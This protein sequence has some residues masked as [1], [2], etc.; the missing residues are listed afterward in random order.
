MLIS[1]RKSLILKSAGVVLAL[2]AL[3]LST[4]ATDKAI[5]QQQVIQKIEALVNDQVVSAFD[6][7]ERMGLVLMA[8]GQSIQNE[9]QLLQLREQV[10]E[11]LVNETL[12]VQEANE[13]DVPVPEGEIFDAYE[14]V[15]A[16]YNR[17]PDNFNELLKSFGSSSRAIIRQISAEYAWQ[18][19][20][21]GRYGSYVEVTDEEI[22]EV[23][24][25]LKDN[26]GQQEFRISE[27]FLSIDNPSL[28][29]RVASTAQQIRDQIQSY[30]QFSQIARQFSQS[31]TAAQ[32]GD[33]GWVREGQIP[34]EVM[35]V[36]KMIDVLTVSAPIKTT[37]G[38]YIIALTDRRMI[39]GVD[40]LDEL[41][42]LK[43][44]GWF[45]TENTTEEIA[46]AW[47]E[48]AEQKVT[49]FDSC[50]NLA[51]FA[52]ELGDGVLARDVGEVPL[53]QLNPELRTI[54]KAID[55]N[56]A[57]PPINTPD[58]FIIFVVCGRRMPET[59]MPGNDEIQN[60]MEQQRIAMMARRYLRDLRRDAIIDYK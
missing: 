26:A 49:E 1:L 37:S 16:S 43:Q 27:I 4:T 29:P 25:K 46:R 41:L 45:F 30:V 31:T 39:M 22:E 51:A 36:A 44:I 60:Q 15:A 12:Q 19:L 20:V 8:T 40:P 10:L 35:A 6:V 3:F 5:A 38:Y 58:G 2:I 34:P 17:T 47:Y 14:R 13:F 55:A 56:Q 50:D 33:L 28:A 52:G 57:T 24:Q 59:T 9:E 54:L 48:N 23:I 53:K 32:G 18:T 7:S 42:E 11:S 21:N